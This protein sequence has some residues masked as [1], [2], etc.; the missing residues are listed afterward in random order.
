MITNQTKEVN[1][2]LTLIKGN[3]TKIVNV[4]NNVTTDDQTVEEL[5]QEGKV[6]D[7]E[8]VVNSLDEEINLKKFQRYCPVDISDRLEWDATEAGALAIMLCSSPYHGNVYRACFSS[9]VWDEPDYTEC[10]LSQLKDIQNL[11]SYYE[12]L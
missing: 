3:Q 10:R 2:S 12:K 6:K 8:E 9:G 1:L 7:G 11:V 5:D 4:S